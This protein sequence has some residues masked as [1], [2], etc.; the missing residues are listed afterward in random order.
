[1]FGDRMRK[2]IAVAVLAAIPVFVGGVASAYPRGEY[3]GGDADTY[4]TSYERES[5]TDGTYEPTYRVRIDVVQR[6]ADTYDVVTEPST[7]PTPMRVDL[8]ATGGS[9]YELAPQSRVAM[10]F[11]TNGDNPVCDK[12]ADR[13]NELLEHASGIDEQYGSSGN[14]FWQE[15]SVAL[16]EDAFDIADEANANGCDIFYD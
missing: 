8:S 10:L 6:D 4:E 14:Q 2:S 15:V 7:S 1:M 13:A 5:S 3:D 11:V 16:V 9:V 12:A